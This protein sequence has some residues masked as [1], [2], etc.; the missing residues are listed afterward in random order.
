MAH[1]FPIGLAAENHRDQRTAFLCHMHSL[2]GSTPDPRP[3]AA[4]SPVTISGSAIPVK[5]CRSGPDPRVDSPACATDPVFP[6]AAE[7]V[8]ERMGLFL[9]ADFGSVKVSGGIR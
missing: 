5:P 8:W 4:V 6:G 2:V 7:A 3:G 9:R 1:D